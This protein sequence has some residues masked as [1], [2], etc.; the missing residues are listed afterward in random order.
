VVLGSLLQRQKA[1]FI[2]H[3]KG[4]GEKGMKIERFEDIEAWQLAR[5]LTRGVYG[6]TK[7]GCFARDYGLRDQIQRASGSI[8]HNVAEGFDSGSNAELIRFLGYAQR[9]CTEVQS[10][11][12]V[13]LDQRYVTQVQFTELY[14]S[15]RLIKSKLGSFLKY[16]KSCRVR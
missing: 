9:S 16:L 12:Y 7:E 2:V 14:A 5:D 8:M 6:V 10:Q 1:R 4:K 3:R 13:A 11:L 15:A